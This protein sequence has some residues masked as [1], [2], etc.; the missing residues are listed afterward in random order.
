MPGSSSILHR[1]RIGLVLG[2]TAALLA[3]VFLLLVS[4][5]T[6]IAT[7]V[8]RGELASRGIR[9]DIAVDSLGFHGATAHG[10]LSQPGLQVTL[11]QVAVHFDPQ[12]WVPHIAAVTLDRLAVTIDLRSGTSFKS[13]SG[14]GSLGNFPIDISRA[15][16]IAL[17]DA[18]RME[19]V[20]SAHIADGKP[21]AV[22]AEL[23][24]ARLQM[25]AMTADIK[26]GRLQG[27]ATAHG[28]H[29]GLALSGEISLG[30]QMRLE[31]TAL[32][33]EVP[34]LSWN[35]KLAAQASSATLSLT[36]AGKAPSSLSLKLSAVRV[37]ASHKRAAAEVAANATASLPPE[38]LQP[39]LL[40]LPLLAG[41]IQT[42]KAVLSAL[43]TITAR[44][45]F[46]WSMADNRQEL[47]LLEPAEMKGSDAFLLRVAPSTLQM[48]GT[49]L[50]G[51]IAVN[52]RAPGVPQLDL[53]VPAFTAQPGQ[54][55]A[56]LT[57]KAHMSVGAMRDGAI[58]A[59]AAAHLRGG[60]LDITLQRCADL[61]LG[62]Y[63]AKHGRVL[64]DA[65]GSLCPAGGKPLI[66]MSSKGW[67]LQ[68]EA[69]AVSAALPAAALQISQGEAQLS[70]MGT[71]STPHDGIIRLSAM[72]SDTSKVQRF[73]PEK[74]T[75]DLSIANATV[76]AKLALAAGPHAM[77]IGTISAV[78]DFETG[79]GTAALEFPAIAFSPQG[80]QPA[81]I[82][83]LFSSLAQ[84]EGTAKFSGHVGWTAKHITSNGRLDIEA[85]R[86]ASPLGVAQQLSTHMVF[87]SLLPP[88]TA[89]DQRI[90]IER[91]DWVQ[92]LTRTETAVTLTAKQLRVADTRTEVTGGEVSVTPLDVP[93]QPGATVHGSVR[94]TRLA[95]GKLIAASN[96][97][98]KLKLE[99]S[100]S[101]TLPFTFGPEGL[102]FANGRI[103]SDGPGRLSINRTLWGKGETN[104][105]EK[106]AYQALENL[107][108][109]SLSATLESVPGG[110]LRAVFHVVGYD[111]GPGTSHTSFSLA[112]LLTGKAFQKEIPIPR[113]TAIN[114][115]LDT[116]LNFDELLRGYQAT[117]S[118]MKALNGA[119][120]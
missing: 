103:E 3:V 23:L 99:G 62:G 50:S 95:L 6:T 118:Q 69:K 81:Q 82:S 76:H 27:T 2:V 28:M 57:I 33:L 104:S 61:K 31:Q 19:V 37:D 25:G 63:M 117:W 87:T 52:M 113:G 86:F 44:A 115:T 77:P 58:N 85:L 68:G 35:N 74:V 79:A 75:G 14:S 89:P 119:P 41:D 70:L 46:S 10:V 105:V 45:H 67:T 51:G 71:A 48:Q 13:Q 17:T 22:A 7:R 66:S 55:D 72:A 84:T 102:R 114:L 53:L 65:K 106:A 111:D 98:E 38:M 43:Q 91:V 112:D 26:S 94:I 88:K 30:P 24:P 100:V 116:S 90:A 107:S 73:T 56:A 64:S 21:Q 120:P 11:G 18:G 4:L 15:R 83:P 49:T 47:R 80:L 32:A 93:L 29:V 16:I 110:R 34:A 20:G 40:K 97:G 101:G 54:M 39:A 96:L 92:P 109:Q 42:Q 60:V 36:T 8:L 59:Q 9:S 5:R 12:Y 78:Q 1:F 108:Y